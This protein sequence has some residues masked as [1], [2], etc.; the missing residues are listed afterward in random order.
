MAQPVI[1]GRSPRIISGEIVVLLRGYAFDG[2]RLHD[3]WLRHIPD[4]LHE[5]ESPSHQLVRVFLVVVHDLDARL[6]TTFDH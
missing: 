5:P 2:H 3:Y 4:V 6:T 1:C